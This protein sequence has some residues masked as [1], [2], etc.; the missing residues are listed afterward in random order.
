MHRIDERDRR[1]VRELALVHFANLLFL[2][3][4]I[5]PVFFKN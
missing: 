3:P 4:S 5:L 1:D 2:A